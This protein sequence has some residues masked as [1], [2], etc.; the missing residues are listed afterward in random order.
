MRFDKS[1]TNRRFEA[2]TYL[3]QFMS[4]EELLSELVDAL[5]GDEAMENFQYITQNHNIDFEEE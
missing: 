1:N 4:S 5:S 2:M 3:L